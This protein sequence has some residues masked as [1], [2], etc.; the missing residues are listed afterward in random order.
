MV[1][2]VPWDSNLFPA[3]Q[4]GIAMRKNPEDFCEFTVYCK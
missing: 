1:L 2:I 4:R 3:P